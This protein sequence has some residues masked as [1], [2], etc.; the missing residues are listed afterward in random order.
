MLLFLHSETHLVLTGQLM[1]ERAI[2]KVNY[3]CYMV[4]EWMV[5]EL[6]V[7]VDEL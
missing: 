6:S 2:I 7:K 4:V 3:G 5:L 1:T